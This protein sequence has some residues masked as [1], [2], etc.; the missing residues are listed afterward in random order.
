MVYKHHTEISGY[1]MH[2]TTLSTYPIVTNNIFF[3]YP[4][5]PENKLEFTF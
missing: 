5:S 4:W 1:R 3:C 2:T